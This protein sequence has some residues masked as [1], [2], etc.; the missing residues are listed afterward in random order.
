M[1]LKNKL[2][3]LLGCTALFLSGC[4][5]GFLG[6]AP[7]GDRKEY[8]RAR[9]LYNEQQY[10][11]AANELTQYIYKA[12]NVKRREARA[13]RLLGMSYEQLGQLDKALEVYLEALEFH[14]K[15]VPLLVAAAELYQ[16]AGLVDRS[17]ELFDR[18]QE[19][20][21]H[22]AEAL[23]GQAENYRSFGF[24]S[25]AR[26]YY[27][28]FFELNPQADPVYRARYASTFL[29]QRNYEQ[30]FIHITMALAQDN[31]VP[32]YWLISSKAAFG[33]GNYK[34]ALADLD[35]ALHLAP[36][37]A[38]LHVYKIMGLYQRGL[39]T[40]SLQETRQFLTSRPKDPLALLF[41]ALNEWE[42]GQKKTARFHLKQAAEINPDS[43]VGQVATKLA[44]EWK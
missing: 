16:K 19:E 30:A 38:D 41:A 15:N 25:K 23:T 37:R 36:E 40:Q 14:P 2:L 22:N 17:Q 21:P 43:F 35:T 8:V 9:N 26:T 6:L 5:T 44:Q 42:L 31:S 12:G 28:Q 18:A 7:L 4:S 27:D 3:C 34:Q 39:Y 13:Y 11:Q 1:Y 20:D 32:D 24:Y 33:L 29:N 10:Q